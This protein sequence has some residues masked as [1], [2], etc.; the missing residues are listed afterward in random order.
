LPKSSSLNKTDLCWE[1]MDKKACPWGDECIFAHGEKELRPLP[2]W[3]EKYNTPV[4]T[5][6][7]VLLRCLYTISFCVIG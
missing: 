3:F 6:P 2:K 1:F 7:K 4:K 5:A